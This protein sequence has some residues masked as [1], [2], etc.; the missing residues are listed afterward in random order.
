MVAQLT[1]PSFVFTARGTDDTAITALSYF[2]AGGFE[3][4]GTLLVDPAVSPAERSVQIALPDVTE[5]TTFSLTVFAVDS[6]DNLSS[7]VTHVLTIRDAASPLVRIIDPAP[8]ADYDPRNNLPVTFVAEDPTGID[9]IG[10]E[11]SGIFVGDGTIPIS[12]PVTVTTPTITFTPSGVPPAGGMA[13]LVA[14]AR[15]TSGNVGFSAPIQINVRDVEPPRV[16]AVDPPNGATG[17][18]P[19]ASLKVTFSEPI[20]PESLETPSAISLFQLT[21]GS[22]LPVYAGAQ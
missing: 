6:A 12:P 17:V 1:P 19:E 10:L 20:D 11:I 18:L 13:T 7:P 9:L 2:T 15:D 5:T 4:S 21:F 22:N 8:G 3:T 16:I 14:R